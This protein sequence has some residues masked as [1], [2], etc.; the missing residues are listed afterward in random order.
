MSSKTENGTTTSYL[1][2][3]DGQLTTAGA[4][5]FSYDASGNRTDPGYTTGTGNQ[6]TSNG[7]WTYTYDAEGNVSS[8]SDAAGDVW[9]YTYNNADEMTG[10]S[11]SPPDSPHL[12][13]CQLR[14]RHSQFFETSPS[15]RAAR[16]VEAWSNLMKR[17][18]TPS[19]HA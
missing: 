3:A 8:K 6:T 11:Y 12:S 7:T 13:D 19:S 1:Y 4:A 17:R 9:S 10:A 5:T 16:E 18:V 2:D 14:S 15:V